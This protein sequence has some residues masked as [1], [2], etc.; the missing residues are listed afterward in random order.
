MAD[1]NLITSC[2]VNVEHLT[3]DSTNPNTE[4]YLLDQ[5]LLAVPCN[6]QPAEADVVALYGG[7][8]GKMF[9][10]FTTCSG[11]LETDRITTVSGSYSHQYIVKGK[12]HYDYGIGGAHTETLLEE[13]QNEL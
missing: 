4:G 13:L 10:L 3:V 9:T 6:I 12:Q 5:A 1:A 8:F 2:Y 11:I 7:A